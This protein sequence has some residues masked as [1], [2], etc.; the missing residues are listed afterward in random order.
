MDD[1]S[2]NEHRDR[3]TIGFY[4]VEASLD[5]SEDH[6]SPEVENI[7]VILKNFSRC[8]RQ[9]GRQP[10]EIVISVFLI[11]DWGNNSK[12]TDRTYVERKR[13]YFAKFNDV[14]NDKIK[15]DPDENVTIEDFYERGGLQAPEIRY[16]EGLAVKGSNADMIKTHA[17]IREENLKRRHLQMDSNTRIFN[18]ELLYNETFGREDQKDALNASYYDRQNHYVSAH[19]KIV[20]TAIYTTPGSRISKELRETHLAYCHEH[21]DD[22]NGDDE[23]KLEKIKKN[24][25]YSK[26]FVV[27]LATVGLT[28]PKNLRPSLTA[29]PKRIYL[30]TIG[31]KEAYRI[32]QC[33]ATAVNM[34]WAANEGNKDPALKAIED[35]LNDLPSV[36]VGDAVCNY[37]CFANAVFKHTDTL[38]NQGDDPYDDTQA[39]AEFMAISSPLEKIMI[40]EFLDQVKNKKPDMLNKVM[41]AMNLHQDRGI[42]FFREVFGCEPGQYLASPSESPPRID[43]RPH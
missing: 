9:I 23:K 43:H 12:F 20:Y 3:I 35:Q 33:I 10:P 31:N 5:V 30:A 22:H 7:N 17:I 26:D 39:H 25:I 24:S 38:I 15:V 41:N 13:R 40:K 4:G 36:K 18:F 32:T 37:T 27:A 16:L 21:A 28:S 1:P 19:N 34:S 8:A 14:L 11:P 2:S 42:L 6:I 29:P